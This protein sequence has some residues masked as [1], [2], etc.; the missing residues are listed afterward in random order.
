MKKIYII[1]LLLTI[2]R[3]SAI[4]QSPAWLWAKSAGGG[5]FDAGSCISTDTGGNVLVAGGFQSDS[6]TF[7]TTVLTNASAGTTDFFI[8]KYDA[9]GNILWA[10]SAGGNDLDIVTD[11]STDTNGNTL[12][13]GC[14]N[15]PT[16]TFGST[17]L[18]SAFAGKPDIF[19]VK[20]DASGNVLWAKSAVGSD[21][22]EAFGISMDAT[23]N[24]MV[25]GKFVSDTLFF[26]T[27]TLI[28]ALG[29][30]VDLF[31]VKYDSSGNV[32]W[33][34]SSGGTGMDSGF[35]ISSDANGNIYVAGTFESDT[36]I[37]GTTV[38]TNA[39]AGYTDIFLVKYD[40]AGNALWAKSAGGSGN[41]YGSSISIDI[42]GNILLTGYFR[43]TA[44]SFGPAPLTNTNTSYADLYIVKYDA[45][46]N[47]IW[48]TSA[49]GTDNDY[50][51]GMATDAGGNV[52]VTGRYS[53][54]SISFGTTTL[55]NSSGNH[56]DLFIVKY[57]AS[58]NVLWAKSAGGTDHDNSNDICI[59]AGGNVMVTG[60][61][62]SPYIVFGTDTLVI[63]GDFDFFVAK[64][65]SAIVN[66][67]ADK[68]NLLNTL[69]VF[70]NPSDG[71]FRII[72]SANMDEIKIFNLTGQLIY[73]SNPY[74]RNLSLHLDEAGM[75]FIQITMKDQTLMRK[76]MVSR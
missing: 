14:F 35:R 75:Y 50:S 18:T 38:L 37:F 31:I 9:W 21:Y 73:Q 72:S 34:K 4:A 30:T 19:V 55:F 62:N 11:I 32:L 17:V 15:S 20:Y 5:L 48:S 63:S 42:N 70:P 66:D 29:T 71:Q 64:L 27:S 65:D 58:G 33:V 1:L 44:I 56:T 24:V 39:N 28:H 8:A 51:Q 76:I 6:I 40:A 68:G 52:L 47:V 41:D 7:G 74:E 23:G 46:G 13:T 49:G 10:K 57:S 43:S 22:D 45:S 67:I 2:V 53:S 60:T 36:I 25:T 12:V 16:I 59:D 69:T 54:D 3:W 26:G 61:F